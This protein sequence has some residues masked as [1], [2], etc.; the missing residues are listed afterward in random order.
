MEIAA[1]VY[2]VVAARAVRDRGCSWP[3]TSRAAVGFMGRHKKKN[4]LEGA[5]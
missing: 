4:A 3:D 5:L 2:G 1:N